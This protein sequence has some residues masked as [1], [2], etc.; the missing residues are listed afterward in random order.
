MTHGEVRHAR[1]YPKVALYILCGQT[2]QEDGSGN[3]EAVGGREKIIDPWDIDTGTLNPI[4]Y[5]YFPSLQA[6]KP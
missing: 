6:Y 2:L 4:Q 5:E 3:V 1:Q